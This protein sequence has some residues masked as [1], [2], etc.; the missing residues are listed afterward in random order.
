MVYPWAGDFETGNEE[1]PVA[2]VILSESFKF[3]EE[4]VAIWGP[5]HTENLG[6]EKIIVNIISNPNIRYII[7][8]GTEVK[9]HNPGSTLMALHEFGLDENNR[10]LNAKGAIPYIENVPFDAI[11]RW[12]E[13]IDIIDLI[14]TKD[15][16]EIAKHIEECWKNNPGSFGERYEVMVVKERK[17]V[18]NIAIGE[19]SLHASLKIDEEGG[20]ESVK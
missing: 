7:I 1:S 19:I 11:Q 10:V 14:G 13:Q 8:C 12:Q 2:I 20:V 4:K 6:I 16:K 18:E 15:E 17:K 5:I 9:G 3:D